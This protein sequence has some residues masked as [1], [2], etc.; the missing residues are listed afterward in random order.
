M[1]KKEEISTTPE[2]KPFKENQDKRDKLIG[3]IKKYKKLAVVILTIFF[4][5]IVFGI[6]FS[7]F[8]S[9]KNGDQNRK[10]LTDS[11][12]R[13]CNHLNEVICPDGSKATRNPPPTC[14]YKCPDIPDL[15]YQRAPT[16][17][18][19]G[20]SASI[21]STFNMQECG[22]SG[23]SYY[24]DYAPGRPSS[25][26]SIK[27]EV[28]K[29]YQAKVDDPRSLKNL[30]GI[31][32]GESVVLNDPKDTNI[33]DSFTYTRLNDVT[34]DGY[35]AKVFENN[36]IWEG[37]IGTVGRIITVNKGND[38]YTI[39]GYVYADSQAGDVNGITLQEFSNVLSSVKFIE[40][41]RTGIYVTVL[42]E[43]PYN[44]P[45][46]KE[47]CLT[48]SNGNEII[49]KNKDDQIIGSIKES[50]Y[51]IDLNPGNYTVYAA[52][53]NPTSVLITKPQKVKVE[54]GK[55]TDVK[56][57]YSRYE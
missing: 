39:S 1:D 20:I 45:P 38:S 19:I 11:G 26:I 34:L 14:N 57:I 10:T 47:S 25:R 17:T 41:K 24:K 50:I 51:I 7:V 33:A 27:K 42:K 22:V 4:I 16:L 5:L 46:G 40:P 49:V 48:L 3:K 9:N 31:E 13:I 18:D 44:C 35:T 32:I 56:L 54:N 2:T 36:N 55:L 29:E 12:S 43:T 21:P 30:E 6:A 52:N 23:C 8:Q 53:S 37:D 15:K 28:D